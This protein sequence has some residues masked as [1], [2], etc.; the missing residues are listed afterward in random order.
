[1]S[2]SL[3]TI[4]LYAGILVFGYI[5]G[6]IFG[7]IEEDNCK[8][9][10]TSVISLEDEQSQTKPQNQNPEQKSTI[11]EWTD[12]QGHYFIGSKEAKV[13]FLEYTDYQCPYCQ[14]YFFSAYNEIKENFI[15]EGKIKYSVRAF[16]LPFHDAAKPATYATLC[17]ADQGGFFKMHEALFMFQNEWSYAESV[18]DL[19]TKYASNIGLDATTFKACMNDKWKIKTFDK[20]ISANS[21]EAGNLNISGTPSMIINNKTIVGAQ[22]Y[23]VFET[24]INEAISQ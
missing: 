1:M 11:D 6:S 16:P 22:P 4:P 10:E 17:A 12:G 19:F 13:T 5:A 21:T 15:K 7:T 2:K 3:K 24:E 9:A 18:E 20:I 8:I 23:E 14:R